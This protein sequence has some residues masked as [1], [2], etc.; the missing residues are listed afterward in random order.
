MQLMMYITGEGT[1][2]RGPTID[3]AKLREVLEAARQ[4]GWTLKQLANGIEWVVP[5]D[6]EIIRGRRE[7]WEGVS[8]GKEKRETVVAGRLGE[9]IGE[10][11]L[12]N[13][14]EG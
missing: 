5:A 3:F 11:I 12:H 7:K 2:S 6:K 4:G 13:G 9:G 1:E 14:W 8:P 10:S